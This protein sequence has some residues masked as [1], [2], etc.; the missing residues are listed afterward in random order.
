MLKY[1][2]FEI[3][4]TDGMKFSDEIVLPRITMSTELT[5]DPF[6]DRWYTEELILD[7]GT[8]ELEAITK[9]KDWIDDFWLIQE[10]DN[11]TA[12]RW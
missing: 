12:F 8:T 2:E 4:F 7:E 5:S 11:D 9:A 6:D 10:T 3:E 1:K